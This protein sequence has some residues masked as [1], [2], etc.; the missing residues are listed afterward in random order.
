MFHRGHWC[1]YCRINVTH[2]SDRRQDIAAAAGQVVIVTPERQEFAREFKSSS[3]APFPILTDLDNG[4]A[5]LLNLA[6]WLSP[7]CRKFCRNATC[8]IITATTRGC[9]QFRRPS[10]VGKDGLV[11]APF[12][13]SGFSHRMDI[14][15]LIAAFKKA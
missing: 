4:Y 15:D 1:P 10:F 6:I 14:E 11:K 13:R 2:W 9:F 5:L 7:I 12:R 8:R 3:H